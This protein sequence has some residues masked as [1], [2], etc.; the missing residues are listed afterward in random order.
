MGLKKHYDFTL[1]VDDA[2]GLGVMGDEGRGTAEH[3]GVTDGVDIIFATFA[4]AM[5][6]IGAFVASEKVVTDFLR[7]NMR[8]QIFAKSL[9]SAMVSGLSADG[10]HER[11]PNTANNCGARHACFK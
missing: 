9:P 4:K 6:G 8:S 5:A 11:T 7:Y 1:L 3:F 2:H 10:N